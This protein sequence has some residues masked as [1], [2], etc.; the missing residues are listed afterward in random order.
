MVNIGDVGTGRSRGSAAR[1]VEWLPRVEGEEVRFPSDSPL[2]RGADRRRSA[3][4]RAAC[5]APRARD[6]CGRLAELGYRS[7]AGAYDLT[8]SQIATHSPSDKSNITIKDAAVLG[9][10]GRSSAA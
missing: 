3:A 10:G 6:W 5:L 4:A 9:R 7:P 8:A 1:Q 2:R